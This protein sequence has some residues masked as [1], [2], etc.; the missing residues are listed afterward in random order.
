MASVDGDAEQGGDVC[1]NGYLCSTL[2][3]AHTEGGRLYHGTVEEDFADRSGGVSVTHHGE[4]GS[5]GRKD[6]VLR[7]GGGYEGGDRTLHHLHGLRHA[8]HAAQ[9]GQ[10]EREEAFHRAR[11]LKD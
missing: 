7:R 6:Y 8:A 4:V 10:C 9:R 11:T 1:R 5:T 3:I 2:R